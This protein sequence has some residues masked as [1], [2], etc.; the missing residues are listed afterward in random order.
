MMNEIWVIA[1]QH[2]AEQCRDSIRS[3]EKFEYLDIMGL[4]ETGWIVYSHT[5]SGHDFGYPIN[6]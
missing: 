5:I 3:L 1:S 2:I 6:E 4:F